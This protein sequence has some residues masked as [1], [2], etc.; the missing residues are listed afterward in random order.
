MPRVRPRGDDRP[1]LRGWSHAVA[2]ISAITLAPLL[3]V[4]APAGA[5]RV[6]ASIYSIGVILV[7]SVSAAYHRV[8]FFTRFA[9]VARR[10]DHATIFVFIAATYTPF[11][12]VVLDGTS[13]WVLLA[14][15]WIGAF[16]GI[17]IRMLWLGAPRAV[18]IA[19]YLVVGWCITP[20]LGQVWDRLGPAGFVL[21][22]VG[23]GIY[24]LGALIYAGKV[25]DPSPRWFGY[26]EVFHLLVVAAVAVHYVAVAFFALPLAA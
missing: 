2:A 14:F 20:F 18:T 23:G 17:T 22:A 7:F 4:F 24:T 16:V 26:H 10:L 12:L 9:Q 1:V 19:P 25:P 3:I 5:G 13:S 11:A 6:A 8:F 15:V 21:L